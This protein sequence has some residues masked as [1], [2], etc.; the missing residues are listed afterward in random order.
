[1]TVHQA[2]GLEWDKVIVGVV[3]SKFDD[4]TLYDFGVILG[5]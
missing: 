3:P 5:Y 1:M 4:T 2:K